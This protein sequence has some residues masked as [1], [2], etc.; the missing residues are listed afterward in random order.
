M[1]TPEET[2]GMAMSGRGERDRA[3]D[4]RGW[5]RG[6]LV[7]VVIAA[8]LGAFGATGRIQ[9]PSLGGLQIAGIAVM[10]ASLAAVALAKKLAARF[11]S[12]RQESAVAVIKLLGVTLCAVGAALV[13]I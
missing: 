2:G 8:A 4:F 3:E 13:F 12:A 1:F 6:A 5:I 7:V 10:C 11:G 9:R